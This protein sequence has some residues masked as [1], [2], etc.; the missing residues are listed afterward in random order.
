MWRA[1]RRAAPAT[2]CFLAEAALVYFSRRSLCVFFPPSFLGLSDEPRIAEDSS[3]LLDDEESSSSWRGYLALAFLLI[4]GVLVLRQWTE[5]RGIATDFAQRLGI[6][7]TPKRVKAQP[8]VSSSE[9]QAGQSASQSTGTAG[10]NVNPT[11]TPHENA[12]TPPQEVA[13]AKLVAKSG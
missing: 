6:A 7:D 3:Y 2:C 12:T 5:M 4:L 8:T 1:L 10:E 13:K 9:N 11:S